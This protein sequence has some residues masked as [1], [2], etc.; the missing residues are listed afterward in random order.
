MDHFSAWQGKLLCKNQGYD[1]V[2]EA[3]QQSVYCLKVANVSFGG[4]NKT[5]VFHAIFNYRNGEW[6]MDTYRFEELGK[7]RII[8][9]IA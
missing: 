5:Y 8:R 9:G 4:F 1:I 6:F 2:M 3:K 7:S